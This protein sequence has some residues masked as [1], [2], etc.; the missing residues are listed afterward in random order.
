MNIGTVVAMSIAKTN[1]LMRSST[2]LDNRIL[3]LLF[4]HIWNR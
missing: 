4:V 3:I 1:L 2:A